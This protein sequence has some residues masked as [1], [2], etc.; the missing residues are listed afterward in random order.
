M[1]KRFL[2]LA[3]LSLAV[4]SAFAAPVPGADGE[5]FYT[6]PA[7]I[8]AGHG[9]LL[10]YRPTTVNLKD[11]TVS[12][13]KA[14]N[15]M[16]NTQSITKNPRTGAQVVKTEVATGTV[17]VPAGT[18]AGVILYAVGTHGLAS[19]CAPSKQLAAGTDYENANI[20]AALKAGYTVL[21][22][23]YVG[24]TSGKRPRYM[25]GASQGRA[26]LDIF[27]AATQIPGA[28]VNAG[29]K[30]AIWG[31]SQGGQSSSFAAELA[32]SYTPDINIVGVATG[33]VPGDFVPTAHYL[34]GRN[35]A[36]FLL[37]TVLG[38]NEE[39]GDSAIPVTLMISDAAKPKIEDLRSRCVFDALFEYQNQN[40]SSFTKENTPF[41][42]LLSLVEGTLEEQKLGK[43]KVNFPVYQYHGKA[44]QFIPLAQAYELKKR[45]CA[46][47]TTVKFDTYPSEHIATQFQG[48]DGALP[49]LKDRFN[50][51]AA[52]STC[53]QTTAP[54]A[55]PEDNTGP[56][57]VKLDQWP[58][59][60]SV[61]VKGLNQTVVLPDTSSF[62]AMTD[63]NN[64]TLR[65]TLNVPDFKQS[66][67]ILGIG[68]QVGLKI[69]PVGEVVGTAELSRE[70]ILT[71]TGE[72]KTDITVTSVWGIPFGQ[73]KTVTPVVFPLNFSGPISS[74]G[75]G[76]VFKNTTTFPQIKGC[77]ISA[78]ISALMSGSGQQYSFEVNPPAPKTN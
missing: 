42:D 68:A 26:V 32:P 2:P 36:S 70:G 30:V 11:G 15:V 39:Y 7:T 1:I 14:W 29:S 6:T 74:L 45:W 31:Y 33:G 3:A 40:L 22:T 21:V 20:A 49:W 46:L 35:G 44:D 77:I 24:Y 41:E 5:A 66:L 76:L 65:G 13:A 56:I 43:T 72:A 25:A 60:A 17:F 10:T 62:S 23:D 18:S 75:N 52:P 48:A 63:I 50:N 37:S 73:C 55:T 69:A 19:K 58:L 27:K 53:S 8:P 47:G 51:V 12:N 4:S 38:L 61:L 59:T 78:I 54:T 16:Y 28:G 57:K 34:N 67:K 71:V 64:K 9:E